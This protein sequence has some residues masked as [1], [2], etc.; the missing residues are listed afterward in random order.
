MA[1]FEKGD[2]V[3]SSIDNNRRGLVTK[4]K[5]LQVWISIPPRIEG[6]LPAKEVIRNVNGIRLIKSNAQIHAEAQAKYEAQVSGKAKPW[7]VRMREKARAFLRKKPPT[8]A[9]R[10]LRVVR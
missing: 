1:K 4:C 2:V 8:E 10:G 6:N 9:P 3:E 7:H 5:G